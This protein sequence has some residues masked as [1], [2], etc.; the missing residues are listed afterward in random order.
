MCPPQRLPAR[1]GIT[2]EP[3]QPEVAER[4]DNLFGHKNCLIEVNPGKVLMPPRYEEIGD[5]I[6]MSEVRPDDVWVVSY[7]RTGS[8]W[9]QE[10]VWCIGND[11]DFERA[12][13]VQQFRTP[14]IE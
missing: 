12:K 8:T 9:A 7:P 2:Y 6:R 3:L 13:M 10:M 4:I 14:L 1:M 11:L 5:R